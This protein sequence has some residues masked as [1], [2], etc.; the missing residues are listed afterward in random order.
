[1]RQ[2]RRGTIVN[3]SSIGGKLHEPL[4]SWY[5]ATK[6]AVEGLSDCLRMELEPFGINVVVVEPGGVKSEWAS[7]AREGLLRASGSG[8]Y[9]DQVRESFINTASGDFGAEPSTIGRVV[10]RAVTSKRPRTR[11]VVGAAADMMLALRR[12][13]PDRAFDRVLRFMQRSAA[14]G[15]SKQTLGDVVQQ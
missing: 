10:V 7:I 11:Y 13:L 1:M 14:K 12:L 6:F 2:H 9:A 3:I 8:P 5:H 4:G 15:N